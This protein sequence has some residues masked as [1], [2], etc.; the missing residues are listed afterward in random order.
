MVVFECSQIHSG[1]QKYVLTSKQV[2]AV[3]LSLRRLGL[4]LQL[5]IQLRLRLSFGSC[6]PHGLHLNSITTFA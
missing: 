2:V 1:T 3:G 5:C 4:G 6:Q